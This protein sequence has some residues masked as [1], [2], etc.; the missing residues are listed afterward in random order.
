MAVDV[1]A[2]APYFG[3]DVNGN[4]AGAVTQLQA[5][6]AAAVAE[7]AAQ[8]DAVAPSGLTL[9]AYEGGQ[10]VFNGADVVNAAPE[11][12]DM[13]TAYLDGVAPYL[14]LFMHYLHNGEWSSGGAWG[15]ERYVG[16]PLAEAHKL[17]AIFDW[18][19]SHP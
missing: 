12:Y 19:D 10:S 17:R 14:P 6:V 11:M 7:V 9:L 2:I 4:D 5:T 13:Y 1:Y 8:H 18:L 16:Q 3:G 15:A